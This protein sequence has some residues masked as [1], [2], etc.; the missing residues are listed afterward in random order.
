M[1]FSN[2]IISSCRFKKVLKMLSRHCFLSVEVRW[3]EVL[4]EVAEV[5]RLRCTCLLGKAKTE[6]RNGDG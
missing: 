4:G 5:G 3:N 6:V 1:S 2:H